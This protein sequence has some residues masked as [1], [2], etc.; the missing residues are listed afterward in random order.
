MKEGLRE[1]KAYGDLF[2]RRCQYNSIIVLIREQLAEK[3]EK[4]K[5]K[6]NWQVM[7]V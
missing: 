6:R 3:F 1:V 5:F 4:M 2:R 7:V